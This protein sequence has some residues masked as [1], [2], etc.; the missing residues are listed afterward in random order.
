MCI[1]VISNDTNAYTT[2][3]VVWVHFLAQRRIN[4][5]LK[6]FLATIVDADTPPVAIIQIKFEMTCFFFYIRSKTVQDFGF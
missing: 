3:I 4:K 1:F 6:N 5:H 2:L